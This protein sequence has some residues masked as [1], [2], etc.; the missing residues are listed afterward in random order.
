MHTGTVQIDGAGRVVL[1]KPIRK[2]LNLAA[3]DKLR[4]AADE[5]GV[6]LEPVHPSGQLVRKKGVLVFRGDFPETVTTA[7]VD[8]LIAEDRDRVFERGGRKK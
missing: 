3:G 7:S 5:S 4:F 1:P 8:Q 2:R 6:R